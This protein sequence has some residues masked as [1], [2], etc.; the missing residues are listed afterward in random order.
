MAL[1]VFDGRI[2]TLQRNRRP[3]SVENIGA[4]SVVKDSAGQKLSYV[5]YDE[6]PGRRSSAKL[7]TRDEA[8]RI[9]ANIAKLPDLLADRTPILRRIGKSRL[10]A[11]CQ[12]WCWRQGRTVFV[13]LILTAMLFT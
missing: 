1:V 6:E 9:A 11:G 5:Y 7:M 13:V 12:Q 4:A 3:W 10:L 2:L 8:R